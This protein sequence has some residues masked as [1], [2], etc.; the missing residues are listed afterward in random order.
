MTSNTHKPKVS[1][2][3]SI[4]N[5]PLQWIRLAVESI[6][7]QTF[8]DFEFIIVCDSPDFAE[9]ISYIREMQARDSRIRVVEN[10]TNLGPTRSFNIAIGVAEGE[11]IARMDADDISFEERF[12][13]QTA[14]LDTHPDVYVC[15][16]DVHIIDKTGRIVR[17]RRFRHKTDHTELL[18]YNTVS[19]P[20][21]M[22]RK[23][24]LELRNPIYNEDFIYS[25]D[26]EL[27]TYLLMK[28]YR[29]QTL[30]EPLLLYRKSSIQISSARKNRQTE[31]FKKAHRE[32]I[33][34]W[35]TAKGII[36]SSDRHE[37]KLMLRKASSA[38]RTS[39]K[40]DQRWLSLIIYVLYFSIGT[41]QWSYRFK[42][43][44]DRNMTA[45]RIKFMLTFRMFFSRKTRRDRSGFIPE[46]GADQ[47]R[48]KPA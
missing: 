24:L 28:G 30:E 4:N 23:S 17:K 21:V 3:M 33:I 46:K 20:S 39:D 6:L 14:F 45:F 15:A 40:S 34:S 44:T 16:T 18:L 26:Y 36:E 12:E 8:R 19:H 13:R 1:V 11:Y 29:I 31:L 27:W 47:K 32:F 35:L 48:L 9:G 10:S 42:Y 7:K 37:M 38:F 22:F 2:V 25:Q 5:D 43:L 41:D